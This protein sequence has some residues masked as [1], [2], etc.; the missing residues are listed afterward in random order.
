ML[1]QAIKN[2]DKVQLKQILIRFDIK[3]VASI[4]LREASEGL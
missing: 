2:D 1:V 4:K 3:N